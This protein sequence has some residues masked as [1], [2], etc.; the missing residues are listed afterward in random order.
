MSERE[1]ITTKR[2]A[3][4]FV[5]AG[6]FYLAG[7]VEMGTALFTHGRLGYAMVPVGAMF[8]CVGS[9]WLAIGAKWKRDATRVE[10]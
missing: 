4:A 1:H 7:L 8:L 6:L 10:R 5:A 3:L 2:H 9:M